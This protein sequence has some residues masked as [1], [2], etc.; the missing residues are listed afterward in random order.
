MV[1]CVMY[2][3]ITSLLYPKKLV[4]PSFLT[5]KEYASVGHMTFFREFF[6]HS[7]LVTRELPL[8]AHVICYSVR[9][10]QARRRLTAPL[11]MATHYLP[12]VCCWH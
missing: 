4:S 11:P 2:C 9:A 6:L 10:A 1:A 3:A 8:A 7:R 12:A 5:I